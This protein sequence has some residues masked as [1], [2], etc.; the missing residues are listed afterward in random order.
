VFELAGFQLVREEGDHRVYTKAG[1]RRPIVIPSYRAVPV[2]IIMNNLHTAGMSRQ[3]YF[4]LLE[5]A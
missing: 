4:A 5:R 3:E 2:F 1:V